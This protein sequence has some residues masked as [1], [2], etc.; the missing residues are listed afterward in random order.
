MKVYLV[1]LLAGMWM[2]SGCGGHTVRSE[3]EL[4]KW[5]NDES[6]GLSITKKINGY[7]LNVKYL[8]PPYLVYFE[9]KGKA[10]F[11]ESKR[12]SLI[13]IRNASR[14]FLFTIAPDHDKKSEKD[15]MY[16][17]VSGYQE[18]K[19]RSF[20]M[21]FQMGTMIS[22]GSGSQSVAPAVST[23]E[24]IYSL[25]NQRSLYLVFTEG[26]HEGLFNSEE[27]DFVYRDELFETGTNHFVFKKTDLNKFPVIDI[28]NN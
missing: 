11:S 6:N 4:Y 19:E 7:R 20:A 18:Y 27:L 3:P 15:I 9:T 17:N 26:Q 1:I 24:N 2:F 10:G 13:N 22:L 16:E 28:K 12:D 25:G 8:P 23:M 14:T 21:N 5:L